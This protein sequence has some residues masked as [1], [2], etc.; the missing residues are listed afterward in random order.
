MG[1]TSEHK[2]EIL[3]A[4]SKIDPSKKH[5]SVR[6]ILK[7]M[8]TRSFVNKDE[9]PMFHVPMDVDY[10]S[11]ENS[12]GPELRRSDSKD[13]EMRSTAYKPIDSKE[14]EGVIDKQL[15]SKHHPL[16]FVESL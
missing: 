5:F 9:A 6:Q 4:K 16:T 1:N 7:E 11:K 14:Y 3:T 13:P 2:N 10:Q 12:P 15:A 8:N